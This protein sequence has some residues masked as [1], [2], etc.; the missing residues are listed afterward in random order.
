MGA[1]V[2]FFGKKLEKQEIDAELSRTN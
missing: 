1:Y 2:R